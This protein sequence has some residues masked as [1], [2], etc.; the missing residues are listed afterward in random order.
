MLREGLTVQ[1]FLTGA[2]RAVTHLVPGVTAERGRDGEEFFQVFYLISCA[3]NTKLATQTNM[4]ICRSQA[5]T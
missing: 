5:S 1:Q 2:P 4:L 3:M